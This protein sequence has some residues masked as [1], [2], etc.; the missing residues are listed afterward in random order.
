M[1]VGAGLGLL[2]TPHLLAPFGWR[3]AFLAW[4]ALGLAACFVWANM[5]AEA[6]P[7]THP[8]TL[9]QVVQGLRSPAVLC[10][11]LV[12]LGTLGL[13]QALAPWLALYFAARYGLP[14]G[15]AAA[16]GSIGL[17]A[18]IVFR[19]LGGVLLARQAFGAVLLMRLGTMLACMGVVLLALPAPFALT[20]GVGIA[21]LA[22]GTTLP[23]AAV[24]SEAGRVG[25]RSGLGTGTAQGVVAL[26]SAPASALGP[27]LIGLLVQREGNFSLALGTLALTGVLAI[28]A[29]LL[30]G[31][32]LTRAWKT[33]RTARTTTS[34]PDVH[35][36]FRDS[37]MRMDPDTH[38]PAA[39]AQLKKT[40]HHPQQAT[41][42]GR[43]IILMPGFFSRA[44][45]G[46]RT[47][48]DTDALTMQRLLKA[49]AMPVLLPLSPLASQQ[50]ASPHQRV[51]EDL[52]RRLF[53]EVIW[54]LF[55]QMVLQQA[56]GVCLTGY[57]D[58]QAP[59]VSTQRSEE[60]G[61]TNQSRKLIYNSIVL[62]AR[63]IGMPVLSGEQALQKSPQVWGSTGEDT[64]A[65]GPSIWTPL[66]ASSS[67]EKDNDEEVMATFSPFVATCNAYTPLPPDTL[68]A[69][70]APLYAWLRQ[71]QW[72]FV[73][74]TAHLQT[75]SDLQAGT[76]ERNTRASVSQASMRLRARQHK[77]RVIRG[78]A[79]SPGKT[80]HASTPP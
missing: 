39:L 78:T 6:V 26:L 49:G 21:L 18:G 67:F 41:P 59:D 17:F 27:P 37:K 35:I 52:F 30:A 14:L 31:P 50:D 33:R 56:R 13:G 15:L 60:V 38:L 66:T 65:Q 58:R 51:G 72:T 24:L 8:R 19:P 3:G 28:P 40:V 55:C 63:V 22:F 48:F 1:Q 32:A 20:A 62:L 75:A 36:Q 68:R 44:V 7:P 23:Y 53:D 77:L 9:R 16:L 61:G 5:P 47:V 42:A 45:D 73:R 79:C 74:Q 12:H 29:A 11:G 2:L 70:Q 71:K 69:L 43:P 80:G 46:Q 10:L 34:V 25:R 54:P 4:G 76:H 57:Q 64:H